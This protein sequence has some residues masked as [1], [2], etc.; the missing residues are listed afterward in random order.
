MDKKIQST[1]ELSKCIMNQSFQH[2]IKEK[3]D[4]VHLIKEVKRIIKGSLEFYKKENNIQ[5]EMALINNVL[6]KYAQEQYLLIWENQIDD[7]EKD[8]FDEIMKEGLVAFKYLYKF[9]DH[10]R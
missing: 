5:K 9:E 10:K 8:C 1:I 6:K 4:D 7:D 3:I 2:A